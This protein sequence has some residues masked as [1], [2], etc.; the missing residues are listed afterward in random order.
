MEWKVPYSG[1]SNRLSLEEAEA[2]VK[3]LRQDSLNKGPTARRFEQDW[4]KTCPGDL[5][6]HHRPIPFSP[7]PGLEGG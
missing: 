4:G 2:L 6:V 7:N 3:V 5:F 1:I